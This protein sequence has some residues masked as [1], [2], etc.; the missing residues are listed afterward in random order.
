MGAANT[1]VDDDGAGTAVIDVSDSAEHDDGNVDNGA[2][3]RAGRRGAAAGIDGSDSD[4]DSE[5]VSLEAI[6]VTSDDDDD[7]VDDDGLAAS[8][9]ARVN[10]RSGGG[11]AAAGSAAASQLTEVDVSYDLNSDDDTGS[12]D[13]DDDDSGY[14]ESGGDSDYYDGYNDFL[15]EGLDDY[16]GAGADD[17]L[18]PVNS[19]AAAAAFDSAGAASG[20][21]VDDG[22]GGGGGGSGMPDS[23]NWIA[24]SGIRPELSPALPSAGAASRTGIT[25]AATERAAT[26]VSPDGGPW[27]H[28]HQPDLDESVLYLPLHER[29]ARK[30]H[31]I[32]KASSAAKLKQSGA[33]GASSSSSSSSSASSAVVDLVSPAPQIQPQQPTP[34]GSGSAHGGRRGSTHGAL[35]AGAAGQ[36]SAHVLPRRLLSDNTKQKHDRCGICRHAMPA[37][38]VAAVAQEGTGSHQALEC[39]GASGS[40]SSSAAAAGPAAESS[41]PAASTS[42][43]RSSG[44]SMSAAA[45]ADRDLLYADC[46]SCAAVFH[47]NCLADFA[48]LAQAQPRGDADA[49]DQQGSGGAGA[50]ASSSR[51]IGAGVPASAGPRAGAAV[52][53]SSSSSASPA[54]VQVEPELTAAPTH[55]DSDALLRAVVPAPSTPFACPNHPACNAQLTWQAVTAAAQLRVHSDAAAA[56]RRALGSGLNRSKGPE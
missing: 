42:E 54:A 52:A 16:G 56:A 2:R 35:A 10:S 13:D 28:H 50:C 24:R 32:S 15:R 3:Y 6:T 43:R 26:P 19:P 7:S 55:S 45:I 14:F 38:D 21:G 49:D 1:D 4:I 34:S 9:G 36:S 37:A 41:A 5:S 20:A 25:V 44:T 18:L 22:G 30:V 8:L 27:D 46:S 29:L 47:L 51:R 11:G 53:S 39:T 48:I 12:D 23:N 40:G 33:A 17:N 31:A